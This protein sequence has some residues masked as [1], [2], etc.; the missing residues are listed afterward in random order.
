MSK[1]AT[2]TPLD[3]MTVRTKRLLCNPFLG[4]SSPE[5]LRRADF[6]LVLKDPACEQGSFKGTPLYGHC[7]MF[8]AQHFTQMT[9]SGTGTRHSAAGFIYGRTASS[10]GCHCFPTSEPLAARPSEEKVTSRCRMRG[11]KEPNPSKH[12][13]VLRFSCIVPKRRQ[14]HRQSREVI[15]TTSNDDNQTII[16][17]KAFWG[18][19]FQTRLMTDTRSP[20]GSAVKGM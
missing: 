20:C 11:F 3:P 16:R 6:I 13:R 8:S 14:T 15:W 2:R 10:H 17:R 5:G 4:L 7:R 19:D 12:Q 1:G 9:S 18:N